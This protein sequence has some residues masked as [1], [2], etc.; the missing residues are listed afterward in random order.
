MTHDETFR[1]LRVGEGRISG[2]L[3]ITLGVLSLFGVLCFLFPD[4][5]TTPS[6]REGYAPSRRHARGCSAPGWCSPPGSGC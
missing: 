4:F 6:L 1:P 3:S 5:L 2:Y